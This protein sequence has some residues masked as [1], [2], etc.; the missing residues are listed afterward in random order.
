MMSFF[1]QVSR[2][3]AIT[4]NEILANALVIFYCIGHTALKRCHVIVTIT[5]VNDFAV[6]SLC[7][8]TA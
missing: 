5:V 2:Y 7:M 3:P 1:G 4:H 6:I 8:I